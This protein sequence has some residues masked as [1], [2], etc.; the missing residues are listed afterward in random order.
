MK[1]ST[2]SRI[3]VCSV[4]MLILWIIKTSYFNSDDIKDALKEE[5]RLSVE[6][7]SNHSYDNELRLS[8][9]KDLINRSTNFTITPKIENS[10]IR[11]SYQSISRGNNASLLKHYEEKVSMIET[12]SN[13]RFRKVLS[14]PMIILSLNRSVTSDV[15]GNL[16]SYINVYI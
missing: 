1:C 3:V 13:V 7:Y 10:S 6:R 11:S 4:S 12:K 14:K 5:H 8:V 9:R 16:G 2:F 15:R